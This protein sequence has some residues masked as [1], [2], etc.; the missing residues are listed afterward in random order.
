[1]KLQQTTYTSGKSPLL[2]LFIHHDWLPVWTLSLFGCHGEFWGVISYV[3]K[4]HTSVEIL[5]M[6]LILKTLFW[7]IFCQINMY[8]VMIMSVSVMHCT[9]SVNVFVL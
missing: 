9:H 6:T 1:M 3:V 2:D 8:L 7:K 5:L 4:Q